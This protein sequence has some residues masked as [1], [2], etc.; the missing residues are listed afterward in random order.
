MRGKL[1]I[2]VVLSGM[3]YAATRGNIDY[4]QIRTGARQGNGVQFQMFGGGSTTAGHS[5]IYDAGGNIIDSGSAAGSGTV[6]NIGTT[7]PITG[8]PITGTGTIACPTCATT[9]TVKQSTVV[10]P[11]TQPI[12]PLG[13][14]ILA[15]VTV[16]NTVTTTSLIG[17]NYWGSATLQP[18]NYVG[19]TMRLLA[20]GSYSTTG[21]PTLTLTITFG[22]VT[23][24]NFTPT[25]QTGASADGWQLDYLFTFA[26]MSSLNSSGCWA[27]MTTHKG[28]CA[29]GT[30]TG[31]NF[32]TAQ[33]IDL[34]ATWSAAS[35]SNSI[36]TYVAIVFRLV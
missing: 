31:L 24:A 5:P 6:T 32:A 28:G 13:L 27:D 14:S 33:T 1:I 23:V 7:A 12:M 2:G 29:S 26:S 4:D 34:T 11:Y 21:S 15:P 18:G 19:R 36:T 8:G 35:S 30:T 20:T 25:V 16:A 22:G 10:F 3:L 9:D 17:A